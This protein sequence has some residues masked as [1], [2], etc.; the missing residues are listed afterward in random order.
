MCDI[1]DDKSIFLFIIKRE[2]LIMVK[3]WNIDAIVERKFEGKWCKA[4]IVGISPANRTLRLLHA[5]NSV[6]IDVDF[7][8]IRFIDDNNPAKDSNAKTVIDASFAKGDCVE[9]D[10][11]GV[12]YINSHCT[13]YSL[14]TIDMVSS[15]SS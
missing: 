15:N 2:E 5:D 10:I 13:P 4:K 8:E 14:S 9:R 7:D 12:S 1:S 6:E 3:T 11:D